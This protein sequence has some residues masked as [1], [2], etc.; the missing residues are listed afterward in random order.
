M[1]R[2]LLAFLTF[3]AAYFAVLSLG[4]F[5]QAGTAGELP[6]HA[7]KIE[8][9]LHLLRNG[10]FAWF[11]GYLGGSPTATLLSYALSVPIYA[12]ALLLTSNH[13]AAMKITGLVLLALGGVAA[14]GFGRRLSGCGWSGFAVGC[15]YL[16]APQILL[17]LGWYEHMTIVTAIPLVPLTFLALLRVAERGTPFDGI[18]LAVSFSA[19]LLGWSKM[20]ATLVIP[21]ALFAGWLFFARRECRRNLVY[22]A[23]WAVPATLLIG[24][25]PLLPLLRER[26]FMTVFELDPFA[27]WQQTYSVKAATSWFDRGGALF[28]ELPL[29]FRM[30]KGGYYL[31]LVGMAA[32]AWAIY[33]TWRRTT[34]RTREVAHIRL[35]VL[36]AL[37][38]FWCS[39]GPRSVI[40]GHFQFLSVAENFPDAGIPLHWLVLAAQGV[41]IYWCLPFW[42][43]PAGRWRTGVFAA[44][45]ALYLFVPAFRILEHLPLYADLRAPESFWILNGTFAWAVG[46]ALAVVFA[47]RTLAPER[48]RVAV[49]AFVLV[50]ACAD[51]APYFHW[52]YRGGLGS[53]TFAAFDDSLSHLSGATG[54]V[55]PVSGR[56]FYLDIP[57]RTG[58]PISTEALNHYLMPLDTARL[59]QAAHVSATDFL[60]Y[61]R[62]AG[63]SDVWLDLHDPD[64]AAPVQKWFRAILPVRYENSS[65]ADLSDPFALYPGFFAEAGAPAGTGAHEYSDALKFAQF[66]VISISSPDGLA[67]DDLPRMIQANEVAKLDLP[68]FAPVPLAGPRTSST[69]TF[70]APGKSGWIVLDESWH[71]D[72][73]AT[74][75]GADV[76]I[77]RGAGAFPAVPVAATSRTVEFRFSPPGWY[78]VCLAVGSVGWLGS[79]GFLIACPLL[80]SGMRRK[81]MGPVLAEPRRAVQILDRPVISR[82]L[83]IVPTYNESESIDELLDRVLAAR[84]DLHVLVIDDASP[85]GTAAHVQDRAEKDSR[86]HLL[87]RTGKL[88]L[89]SAYRTGFTWAIEHG[90]DACIEIDADLSHNP[91]DIPRLLAA[92]DAGADAA[93]GSRYLDGV[94]VLNWPEH[95]LLLSAGASRYVRALTGLP[96]TDATSGFKALRT[97]A[98]GI[99]DRSQ[100]RAD[101]YGFQVELHWLLWNAGFKLAEVPIVFTERRS[102]QTKMTLGIAIEAAWRVMQLAVIGSFDKRSS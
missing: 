31:G 52:F 17:R 84:P 44:I 28:A 54:R 20:G 81:A 65:F 25:I 8:A 55:M 36:I 45:Y 29:Q 18:L 61:L 41:A 39:F 82:P 100:L 69:V 57:N 40:E 35:F 99:I 50:A 53:G 85:D 97:T 27:G 70:R 63:I 51:F 34:Q 2:S 68:D 66:H 33:S 88:G 6:G 4:W 32:V 16:L 78:G 26:G 7:A 95:R 93:I 72:W 47:V 19:T 87:S 91:A 13:L 94:R 64:V 48:L 98:L 59:Q 30:D 96:L 21:L 11:P 80:P 49:A 90:Y 67:L 79:L 22:G 24:V 38:M 102:G 23:A 9:I 76:P 1:R 74:V 12:P 75:D 73:T 77:Y 89:G 5:G 37:V 46:S 56:Y 92:L 101:G 43:L 42:W 58:R 14:Y 83:A 86:V 3:L 10:D 71:P 62:L 60:N 15:A